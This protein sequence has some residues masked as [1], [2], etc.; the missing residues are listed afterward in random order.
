[1]RHHVLEEYTHEHG[2]PEVASVLQDISRCLVAMFSYML[3]CTNNSSSRLRKQD[4]KFLY[5]R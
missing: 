1:M 4:L 2:Y 3:L 5:S